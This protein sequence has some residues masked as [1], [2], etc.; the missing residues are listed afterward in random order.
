MLSNES[1]ISAVLISTSTERRHGGK[2]AAP[3]FYRR[4]IDSALLHY[5]LKRSKSVC[6]KEVMQVSLDT[7]PQHWKLFGKIGM[8]RRVASGSWTL[9][10]LGD[11]S[12]S[13]D[14]QGF[15]CQSVT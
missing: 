1:L 11:H 15:E 7:Q 4:S 9:V 14:W 5:L 6:K 8:Q 12:A 3:S 2:T 10:L 13:L